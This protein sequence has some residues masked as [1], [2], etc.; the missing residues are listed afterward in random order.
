MRVTVPR[1]S[2]LQPGLKVAILMCTFNGQDHLAA[3]LD[4]FDSQTHGNWQLWVSDDGSMDGTPAELERYVAR[5]S[6]DKVRVRLGPMSGYVANFLSLTCNP[7]IHADY[8]AFS[9]QDDVWMA[10]KLERSIRWLGSVPAE[11]PA[12]YCSRTLL[13]DCEDQEIGFSPLFRKPASFA[14]ALM[15]NIGGGN[16]MVFNNAARELLMQAGQDID[17]AMHDWWAYLAVTACGG[18][19]HYDPVPTV[20]YRQHGKNLVGSNSDARSR[21]I[22]I[23]MLW[24]GRFKQLTDQ[25]IRALDKIVLEM[26]T[27]NKRVL[28]SFERARNSRLVPRLLEFARIGLY[29]QTLVGNLG[30]IAATLFNKV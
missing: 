13:V 23:K 12:V 19:V 22:R 29:R 15:Q 1:T 17:V 18:R 21:L 2:H 14:N 26:T 3:Q 6:A 16:T 7:L 8:Y 25:H 9:D 28:A 30:L 20:R 11:V 10:D 27:E 24:N 4:S 5:W